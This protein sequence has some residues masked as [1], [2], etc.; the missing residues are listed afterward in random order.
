MIQSELSRFMEFAAFGEPLPQQYSPMVLISW[1][2]SRR[3]PRQ[4]IRLR[5]LLHRIHD[6]ESDSWS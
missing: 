5:F 4:R 1:C 3:S 6:F 2:S